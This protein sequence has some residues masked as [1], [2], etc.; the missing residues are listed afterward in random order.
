MYVLYVCIYIY[1]HI[2]IVILLLLLLMIIMIIIITTMIII[3]I[4]CFWSEQRTPE[5]QRTS[6]RANCA[7]PDNRKHVSLIS[8]HR[9]GVVVSWY[10]R[11]KQIDNKRNAANNKQTRN[12]KQTRL[13]VEWAA[14]QLPAPGVG[15]FSRA[16]SESRLLSFCWAIF[17]H[18]F[19]SAYLVSGSALRCRRSEVRIPD[20]TGYGK[21]V[22]SKSLEGWAPCNQGPPA[23]RAPRRAFHPDQKDSSERKH[24]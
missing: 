23:S 16:H 7:K 10:R 18:C 3:I 17:I 8:N 21:W 11:H 6:K 13:R 19:A 22:H 2:A 24:K 12:G 14:T 20:W 4:M 1:I 9:K 5:Q 15:R